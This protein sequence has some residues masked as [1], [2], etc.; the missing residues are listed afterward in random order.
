MPATPGTPRGPLA[1]SWKPNSMWARGVLVLTALNASLYL[2]GCTQDYRLLV[3]VGFPLPA[4]VL[5]MREVKLSD[6]P[7][8]PEIVVPREVRNAS[9]AVLALDLLVTAGMLFA[10]RRLVPRFWTRL[11]SRRGLVAIGAAWGLVNSAVICM[12]VWGWSVFHPTVWIARALAWV[13]FL[14]EVPRGQLDPAYSVSLAARLWFLLLALTIYT[15]LA[16]LSLAPR[17]LVMRRGGASGE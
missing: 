8:P 6:Q 15:G 12:V 13:V 7:D 16:T 3:S 11:V 17:F 2:K 1:L 9:L 10:L 4:S 5:E 14:G